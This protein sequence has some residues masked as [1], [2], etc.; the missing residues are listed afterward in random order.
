MLNKWDRSDND[1]DDGNRFRN[2]RSSHFID[3]CLQSLNLS[4][5]VVVVWNMNVLLFDGGVVSDV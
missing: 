3:M 4:V 1:D 5:L 2:Y